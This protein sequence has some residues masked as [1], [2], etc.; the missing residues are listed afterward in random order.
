MGKSANLGL[1]PEEL[2]TVIFV[3]HEAVRQGGATPRKVRLLASLLDKLEEAEN[4]LDT[5]F[6]SKQRHMQ[7]QREDAQDGPYDPDNKEQTKQALVE[8]A[9]RKLRGQA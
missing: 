4:R 2:D 5:P 3:V 6:R 7:M 9:K 1:T 8:D